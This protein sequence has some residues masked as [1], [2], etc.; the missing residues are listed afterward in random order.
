MA[1]YGYLIKAFVVGLALVPQNIVAQAAPD[2]GTRIRMYGAGN[3]KTIGRYIAVSSDSL[4][5][6]PLN[7]SSTRTVELDA[8][9]SLQRSLGVQSASARVRGLLIGTLAG[10]STFAAYSHSSGDDAVLG[11][12]VLG[13]AMGAGAGLIV[14]TAIGRERWQTM[15]SPRAGTLPS[16]ER[17]AELQTGMRLDELRRNRVVRFRT[18]EGREVN[19]LYAGRDSVSVR[20]SGESAE[21]IPIV[22][23]REIQEQRPVMGRFARNGLIIGTIVGSLAMAIAMGGDDGSDCAGPRECSPSLAPIAVGAGAAAGGATGLLVGTLIGSARSRWHTI[24]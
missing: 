2:V 12:S 4:V 10:A 1:G 17:R 3:E 18:F 21:D 8:I 19:G 23:I 24:R 13:A 20:L 5:Y 11:Y 6:S 7:I 15:E 16:A 22:R 9:K 14:G